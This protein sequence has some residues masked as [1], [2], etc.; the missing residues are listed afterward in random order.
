MHVR[1]HR[2]S[3]WDAGA[4]APTPLHLCIEQSR[5]NADS[6]LSDGNADS[7]PKLQERRFGHAAGQPLLVTFLDNDDARAQEAVVTPS[8]FPKVV[9][10]ARIY[11]LRTRSPTSPSRCPSRTLSPQHVSGGATLHVLGPRLASALRSTALVHVNL[12]EHSRPAIVHAYSRTCEHHSCRERWRLLANVPQDDTR[13]RIYAHTIS[14]NVGAWAR[15]V[16]CHAQRQRGE[17][18]DRSRVPRCGRCV[19]HVVDAEYA[20]SWLTHPQGGPDQPSD[21]A[22]GHEACTAPDAHSKPWGRS[23]PG[24]GGSTERSGEAL[25]AVAMVREVASPIW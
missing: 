21:V 12:R 14:C 4:F 18:H 15:R 17:R 11:T 5:S 7:G 22:G 3:Q 19:G 25:R 13:H 10:L 8:S 20:L 23:W 24:R 16:H 9:C 1:R 2:A 6:T